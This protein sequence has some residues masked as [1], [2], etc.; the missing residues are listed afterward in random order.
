MNPRVPI[1]LLA[2]MAASC[3]CSDEQPSQPTPGSNAAAVELRPADP[4]R[5]RPPTS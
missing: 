2:G 4:A 1:L 3:G 5:G